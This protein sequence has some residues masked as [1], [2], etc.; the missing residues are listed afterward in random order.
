MTL[1]GIVLLLTTLQGHQPMGFD[2]QK[3]VHHFILSTTGG[4]ID[5]T[6]RDGADQTN[7]SAVQKHLSHIA[8]MFKEGEFNIPMLVHGEMPSGVETMVRL[9]DRISYEYK[10]TVKGG[11]VMISTKDRDA[12]AA[13]HDFLRYQIKAHKTGDPL[14]PKR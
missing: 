14:T 11:R 10:V 7:R 5:V 12:L 13:I 8:V 3:T 6:V 9:K 4:Y 1:I 2:E